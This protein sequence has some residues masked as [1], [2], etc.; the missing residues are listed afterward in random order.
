MVPFLFIGVVQ[1]LADRGERRDL[2]SYVALATAVYLAILSLSA[3]KLWWYAVPVVPLTAIAVALA[4]DMV[5]ESLAERKGLRRAFHAS[6]FA[7]LVALGAGSLVVFRN[8]Q[9]DEMG[10][11]TARS[12][13]Q[14]AYSYFL[15][16]PVAAASELGK[17]VVLHPG[18]SR[19]VYYVAPTLFY[20]NALRLQGRDILIHS[21]D[22][23]LPPDF[24]TVIVCGGP[25]GRAVEA[26][27]LVAV[28]E[29][30]GCAALRRE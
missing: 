15:R 12:R 7:W 18:Y 22:H 26:Y 6:A 23:S 13:H 24:D 3:T 5:A 25:A 14:D 27:R 2:S 21:P 19:D 16:G 28:L 1:G 20:A 11:A 8:L 17:V 4:L 29:E 10:A 9:L 30:E